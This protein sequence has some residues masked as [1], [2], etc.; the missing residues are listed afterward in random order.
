MGIDGRK[1]IK[2]VAVRVIRIWLMMNLDLYVIMYSIYI[3]KL[4]RL[5]QIK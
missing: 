3:D 4:T 1:L 2:D 5:I